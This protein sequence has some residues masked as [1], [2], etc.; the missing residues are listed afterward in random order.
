MQTDNNISEHKC[1]EWLSD[2]YLLKTPCICI[3]HTIHANIFPQHHKHTWFFINVLQTKNKGNNYSS[4]QRIFLHPAHRPAK[5][6]LKSNTFIGL[7]ERC[8]SP[9]LTYSFNV[10]KVGGLTMTFADNQGPHGLPY[11]STTVLLSL[12]P[13][14]AYY[15]EVFLKVWFNNLLGFELILISSFI[16]TYCQPFL[17]ETEKKKKAALTLLT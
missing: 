11:K 13:Y 3:S 9:G 8:C 14:S 12:Q 10:R 6:R 17:Y 16:E 5:G 7:S 15:S 4:C 2:P 1:S